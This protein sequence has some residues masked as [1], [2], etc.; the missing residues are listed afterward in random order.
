[1]APDLLRA[2]MTPLDWIHREVAEGRL[3]ATP[4]PEVVALAAATLRARGLE[5]KRRRKAE[6]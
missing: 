1:M 5:R 6:R 4:D 3:A 2:A